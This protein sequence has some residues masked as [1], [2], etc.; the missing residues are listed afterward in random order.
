MRLNREFQSDQP[1][2]W[3]LRH[4]LFCMRLTKTRT[5]PKLELTRRSISERNGG[6]FRV[7]ACGSVRK[8]RS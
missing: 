7:G 2:G 5:Q 1:S 4:H 8:I 6:L 3:P